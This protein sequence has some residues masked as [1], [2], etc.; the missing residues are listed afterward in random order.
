MSVTLR[1]KALASGKYSYYLDYYVNGERKYEFLKLKIHKRPKDETEKQHNKETTKLA[2]SIRSKRE[3]QI[4]SSEHGF[5]AVLQKSINFLSYYEQFVTNY[6][7]KD[8]RLASA[9]LQYFKAFMGKEY[10]AC[11][12]DRT[13]L[14]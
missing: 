4:N 12:F 5:E 13:A 1:K 11:G 10:Q 14:H 2:E 9:S 8:K 7:K 3:L 6:P